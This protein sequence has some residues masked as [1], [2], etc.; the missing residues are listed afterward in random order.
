MKVIAFNGSPRKDGNTTILIN[1][2]LR[3]LEREG[4]ETEL[5]QLSGKE[6]RGCIACYK[7]HENQDQRCAVKKDAANEYIE[8]IIKV[9]G[10]VLGSPVYFQDVTPEMKAL[11]DRAGF[12][13]LGN[14]K[15]Y[16]NKVG[17]SLACFRRSGGMHAVDAMNHFFLSNEVIIAGRALGV[18]KEKGEIEKDEEGIQIARSLGQRMTWILRRLHG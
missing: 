12:V 3:E 2:L 10:I 6:I 17:A 14:G 8:K 11:I 15:M 13:G 1:H 5:V 16:R 7:C 9:Q 18:A 4:I